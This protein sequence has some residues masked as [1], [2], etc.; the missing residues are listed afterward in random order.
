MTLHIFFGDYQLDDS[1]VH[2]CHVYMWDPPY[3]EPYLHGRIRAEA[4][5]T[6]LEPLGYAIPLF[7][8]LTLEG[9][10]ERFL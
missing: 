9:W 1:G 6:I 3:H 4:A 7:G 8:S 5:R 10:P 2:A